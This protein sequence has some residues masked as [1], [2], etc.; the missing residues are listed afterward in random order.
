MLF[1]AVIDDED[2]KLKGLKK[3][4]GEEVYKAVTTALTEI[5]VYNPSGG[6]IISELWNY[7]V[8]EKATLQEGVTVLLNLW[9]KKMTLD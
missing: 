2:E 4:Y 8:A 9:K 3:T 7:E 5:N 6:Y 1:Q